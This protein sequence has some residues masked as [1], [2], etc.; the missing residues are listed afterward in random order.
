[1]KELQRSYVCACA[2]VL[3]AWCLARSQAARVKLFCESCKQPHERLGRDVWKAQN[4]ALNQ[5]E[6]LNQISFLYK[7]DSSFPFPYFCYLL[8]ISNIFFLFLFFAHFAWQRLL[9]KFSRRFCAGNRRTPGKPP[10]TCPTFDRYV[11]IVLRRTQLLKTACAKLSNHYRQKFFSGLLSHGRSNSPIKWL[12]FCLKILLELAADE[13]VFV[14]ENSFRCDANKISLGALHVDFEEKNCSHKNNKI[15]RIVRAQLRG[16]SVWLH[17]NQNFSYIME[18][19]SIITTPIVC[20]R[21]NV[22]ILIG[23]HYIL[24]QTLTSWNFG[25]LSWNGLALYC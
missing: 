16:N 1:M 18:W 17:L 5:P 21:R 12:I 3:V 2:N 7:K 25:H 6:I 13:K 8:Q 10:Y 23:G 11:S 4:E 9:L 15:K 14:H 22:T 24:K 19:K 20:G